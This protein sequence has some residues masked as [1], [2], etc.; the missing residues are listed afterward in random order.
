MLPLNLRRTHSFTFQGQF[1]IWIKHKCT[2]ERH[3]MMFSRKLASKHLLTNIFSGQISGKLK[4]IV[5]SVQRNGT[6]DS[7]AAQSQL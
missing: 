7:S 5:L 3:T 1:A 4:R 2:Q 6:D